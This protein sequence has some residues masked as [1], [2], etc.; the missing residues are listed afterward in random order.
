MN[1]RPAQVQLYDLHPPLDDF[2]AEVLQG[3][4]QPQKM[5]PPKFLYDKR[6]AALFDLICTL[7][8]YYL[9]RT[10]MGI[11]Q[12]HAA[13]MANLIGDSVLM[14]FGSGSSQKIR[15]L[16]DALSANPLASD[17]VYVGID[18]SK[19]HLLEACDR[20]TQDYPGLTAIA[21]CADYT[22]PLELSAIEGMGDRHKVA[23]FPGSSIGNLEPAEAVQFLQQVAAALQP[24]GAL[25]IGVDLKKS[26]TIL[27]P[28]YD[29]ALGLSAAFALNVLTRMNREL[30]TNFVVQ[31]F[32]Y[33][34]I[35]NPMGRIEMYLI[36]LQDQTV[37]FGEEEIAFTPGERI[38]TEYSYKYD[39]E[40]FWAIAASAGFQTKQ[41]WTD[42]NQLFSLHYLHL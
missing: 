40:E 5:I 14:E 29:D 4:R 3:L 11:L 2:R 19:Q 7:E 28:A 21:L 39:V 41:V 38:R 36:S 24:E 13:E 10:E 30:G 18:I 32:G 22:Q 8:E 1:S 27:E 35:Y 26:K 23:F 31:N 42:P 12:T 17:P 16:L 15:I 6:G 20:L 33:E 25:L 34:A 37:H 9:T